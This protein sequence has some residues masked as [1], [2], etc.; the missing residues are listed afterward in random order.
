MK[1]KMSFVEKNKTDLYDAI[2][3][4]QKEKVIEQVELIVKTL[5]EKLQSVVQSSA[6]ESI[7]SR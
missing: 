6:I 7:R 4:R 5:A 1:I 3:F 2:K